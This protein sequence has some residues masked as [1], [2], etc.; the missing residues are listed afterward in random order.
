MISPETHIALWNRLDELGKRPSPK[1]HSSWL[2]AF[3]RG[4]AIMI[5]ADSIKYL[6]FLPNNT[7]WSFVLECIEEGYRQKK[8]KR[9]KK[10]KQ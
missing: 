4:E 3:G 2:N 5:A 6:L 9:K 10:G 7:K 1:L 8:R